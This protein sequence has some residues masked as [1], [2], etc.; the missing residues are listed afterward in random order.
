MRSLSALTLTT[1]TLIGLALA[2][3][4]FAGRAIAATVKAKP[5]QHV[6]AG[7]VKRRRLAHCGPIHATQAQVIAAL[8]SQPPSV[9][10]QPLVVNGQ[11]VCVDWAHPYYQFS[12]GSTQPA[13]PERPPPGWR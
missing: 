5:T 8:M 12:D 10:P 6:H 13:R 7:P 9:P 4:S 1:L 11:R 2:A 3:P